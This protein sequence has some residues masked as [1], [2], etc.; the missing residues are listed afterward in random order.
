MKKLLALVM[1]LAMAVMVVACSAP[2]ETATEESSVTEASSTTE[3]TSAETADSEITI[4]VTL[5]SL[6]DQFVSK[7]ATGVEDAAAAAGITVDIQDGN[8]DVATQQEQIRAFAVKGY[9]ALIVQLVD[10]TTAQ[11]VVNDA[12]GIPIIFCNHFPEDIELEVGKTM[13]CGTE[14][15][16]AGMIQA[17]YL[18]EFFAGRTDPI[19]YVLFMGELG[20]EN[21]QSR[22]NGVKTE[23]ENAGFTLEK[24]LEDTANW[25]RATAMDKMQ[26][27][28]STGAEFDCVICNNDE[29]ALG[30]IEA[31]K[32]AGIDLSAIP[33]V[34]ID[35]TEMACESIKSGEM[36][37]SAFQ[38]PVAKGEMC[39]EYA[40][41]AAKGELTETTA[42]DSFQLVTAENVDDFM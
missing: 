6:S 16:K 19:R 33:V 42:Y 14:E 34:G 36:A 27:F 38:D 13:F 40:I 7:L 12:A 21:T 15:Y 9:D 1:V 8:K 3:D 30:C 23:L 20:Y 4:G 18:A 41:K 39:V 24:V 35:A 22:T 37:A 28:L 31:M 32:A 10:T 25:D 5:F 11:S 2:A 29:M 26:T 17:E